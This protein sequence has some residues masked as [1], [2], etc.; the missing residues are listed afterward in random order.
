MTSATEHLAH[1][2]RI[3]SPSAVCNRPV[4]EYAAEVLHAAGWTTRGLPYRDLANIEKINLIAAPPGQSL[5]DHDVDL[6]LMCHTD[7]VPYAADWADALNPIVRDHHLHGC[8]ACDVK[9]F[10]AC[11]LSAATQT[12]AAQCAPGLRIVLTTDEEIGCIGASHL[13]ADH[14]LHP[15]RMV[16]GEPTMLRPARA[17]KGYCLSEVTITGKEAHSAHPTQGVSAIYHAARLIAAIE[18][19]AAQWSQQ[20]NSFFDPPATTV[21]IGTIRGGTAKNIVPGQCTFELE[22][23]PIPDQD[24]AAVL[25]SVTAIVTNLSVAHPGVH[26]EVR[27]LRQQPGFETPAGAALVRKVEALSGRPAVSI[28]FGSEASIF[29]PLAQEIIVFGPG[30]MRTA[31]SSRE[32][33]PLAELEAATAILATLMQSA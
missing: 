16:I 32:C 7:T 28:P 24:P 6:V 9:G 22:W 11:V 21:N 18:D 31:H 25:A 14:A 23:R 2:I 17:G 26:A 20:T 1:L 33:V 10:L 15:R 12:S 19:F 27:P 13:V 29:A 8:G 4:V 3:P 30:D 5:S